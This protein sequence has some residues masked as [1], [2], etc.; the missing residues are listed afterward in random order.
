MS[1]F[2]LE[3]DRIKSRVDEKLFLG[4]EHYFLYSLGKKRIMILNSLIEEK[5]MSLEENNK[6]ERMRL[7]NYL[8]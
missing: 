5:K 3:T 6:D 2:G 1:W 7:R 4:W 8:R